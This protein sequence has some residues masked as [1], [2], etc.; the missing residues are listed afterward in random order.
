MSFTFTSGPVVAG[1]YFLSTIGLPVFMSTELAQ[2][3]FGSNF[4]ATSDSGRYG[5]LEG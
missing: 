4:C 2:L 1:E 5:L 3:T